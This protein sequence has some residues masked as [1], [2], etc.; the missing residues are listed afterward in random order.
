MLK[1]GK[2]F[3]H[4]AVIPACIL[5]LALGAAA[6]FFV[7][8][9]FGFAW[10]GY[11]TVLIDG[12]ADIARVS[13]ELRGRGFE[14]FVSEAT[15][16][17]EISDFDVMEEVSLSDLPARLLPEDPRMDDF[18]AGARFLFRGVPAGASRADSASSASASVGSH[19]LYFPV[20]E[21]PFSLAWKLSGVLDGYSWSIVEWQTVRRFLLLFLFCCVVF[22]CVYYNPGLRAA[23]LVLALPWLNFLVHGDPGIFAAGVLVYFALVSCAREAASFFDHYVYE[24]HPASGFRLPAGLARRAAAG[25]FLVCAAIALAVSSG[26]GLSL[27]P[28]AAGLSGSAAAALL[29]AA[30]RRRARTRREH[31]LFVPLTILPRRWKEKKRGGR[32]LAPLALALCLLAVPL[33]FRFSGGGARMIP[34]PQEVPG[35][36]GFS[37]ENLRQVWALR[38][39]NTLPDFSDYLCHRAFQQGFFYGAAQESRLRDFPLPGAKI[40][41]PRYTDGAPVTRREDTLLTFDEMWYKGELEKAEKSD[42]ARLLLRQGVS[43]IALQSAW[44]VRVDG[45]WVARY[46]LII[47]AGLAPFLFIHAGVSLTSVGDMKIFKF[48]RNQQEA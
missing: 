22:S 16:R 20:R 19:I 46:V 42:F 1:S 29:L 40:T 32:L 18:L 24:G 45:D 7:P 6:S 15:A 44:N 35:I 31:R 17:V 2:R 10:R 13:E 14:G 43:G 12:D 4:I 33:A 26:G 8:V 36:S 23:A 28:L 41:L 21:S 30:H 38:R 39:G 27:I 3:F 34:R 25:A 37:R 48:R 47:A 5:V 11:Y 9:F